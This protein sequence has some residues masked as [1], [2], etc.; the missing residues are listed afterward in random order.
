MRAFPA[1]KAL[2]QG[3]D[4]IMQMVITLQ[5]SPFAQLSLPTNFYV[6]EVVKSPFYKPTTHSF[7]QRSWDVILQTFPS[8]VNFAFS[9]RLNR[10][11]KSCSG[12]ISY[13]RQ[14]EFF[15]F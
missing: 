14:L 8:F 9:T 2:M 13:G 11:H 10:R 5:I 7:L 3:D 6:L 15:T 1:Q 12:N 4:I